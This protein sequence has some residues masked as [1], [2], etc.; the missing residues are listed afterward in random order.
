MEGGAENLPSA[1]LPS[2]KSDFR[3]DSKSG[4]PGR[5]AWP[6]IPALYIVISVFERFVKGIDKQI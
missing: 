3:E 5:W 2:G 6:F 1:Q 4:T